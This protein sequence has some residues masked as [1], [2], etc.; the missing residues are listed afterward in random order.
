VIVFARVNESELVDAI[1]LSEVIAVELMRPMEQQK[2]EQ[3]GSSKNSYE[4]VT[5]FT[6]A[7]QIRTMKDGQNAGRKY[8][9]QGNSEEQVVDIVK[10]LNLLVKKAIEIAAARSM[11]EKFQIQ[12]RVIYSSSSFQTITALLIIAVCTFSFRMLSP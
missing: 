7:F 5:D 8:V 9:F 12:V 11:W 2:S 6:H 1:P 10:K 3:Q 4:S